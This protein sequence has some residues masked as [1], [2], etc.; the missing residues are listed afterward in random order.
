MLKQKLSICGSRTRL[1]EVKLASIEV[2]V[3]ESS[4]CVICSGKK[5]LCHMEQ[6]HGCVHESWKWCHSA[7]SM[8]VFFDCLGDCHVTVCHR[9]CHVTICESHISSLPGD[10]SLFS[11]PGC[12]SYNC[13]FYFSPSIYHRACCLNLRPTI[14]LHTHEIQKT[15][16]SS[17]RPC[18]FSA[19]FAQRSQ[20]KMYKEPVCF[21]IMQN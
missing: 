13:Q 11:Y 1:Y 6:C 3:D 8:C 18:S 10:P 2:W 9:L 5:F 4:F 21:G 17:I 12:T 7:P 14:N 19:P 20:L 15:G 16:V